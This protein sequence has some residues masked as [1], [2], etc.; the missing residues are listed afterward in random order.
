MNYNPLNDLT[1]ITLLAWTPL[2]LAAHPSF[3]A[4]NPAELVKLAK[5]QSVDFSSPGVGSSHHLA[6]EY[7]NTLA[8]TKLVHIPY[9]GAAPAVTDAVSGH[10]PVGVVRARRPD[11][12]AVHDEV[13][14]V[15]DGAGLEAGEVAA[16]AGLAHGCA[17]S[18]GTRGG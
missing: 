15:E 18:R 14:A 9:R 5:S 3:A 7:I 17:G 1:P 8:G 16:G 6:G 13:V 11:L 4:N 2:V 10:V 12:L